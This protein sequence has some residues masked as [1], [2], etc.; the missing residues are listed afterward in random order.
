M[1]RYS[2]RN[3]NKFM[4]GIGKPYSSTPWVDQFNSWVK[5][6]DI[7]L[8]PDQTE[9][10]LQLMYDLA[11]REEDKAVIKFILQRPSYVREVVFSLDG[12][13]Q[14]AGIDF[15]S[16]DVYAYCRVDPNNKRVIAAE[17]ADI[18]NETNKED[19]FNII[20]MIHKNYKQLQIL[21]LANPD[22]TYSPVI[23][24][25]LKLKERKQS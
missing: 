25:L 23:D 19:F 1:K 24:M 18:H 10:A 7:K 22:N 5:S 15:I 20:K 9:E 14:D 4:V 2:A 8:R 17:L 3:Y 6:V 12:L 11:K 21:I 16:G 13:Y